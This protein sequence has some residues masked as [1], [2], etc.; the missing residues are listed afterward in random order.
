[1]G[2]DLTLA[3]TLTQ[4]AAELY[5]RAS[6]IVKAY[7]QARNSLKCRQ[8]INDRNRK[9][10]DMISNPQLLKQKAVAICQEMAVTL[11]SPSFDDLFKKL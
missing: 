1:M 9:Y 5:V 6:W 10:G 7:P 11:T 8:L 2:Y 4:F 3:V